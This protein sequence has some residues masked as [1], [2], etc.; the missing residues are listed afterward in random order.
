MKTSLSELLL[1]VQGNELWLGPLV[2][3]VRVLD[4]EGFLE[5]ILLREFLK[6]RATGEE[7]VGVVNSVWFD[8]IQVAVV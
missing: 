8:V 2:W 5:H 4:E 7:M 6:G 3:L 1:H